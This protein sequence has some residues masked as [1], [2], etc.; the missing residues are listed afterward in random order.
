MLQTFRTMQIE[1]ILK[2]IAFLAL[3]V[4]YYIGYFRVVFDQFSKQLTNT[5]SNEETI[6]EIE[7][8]ALTICLNPPYKPL[9]FEKYGID[10]WIFEYN[11][12][13]D[14]VAN[15][16]ITVYTASQKEIHPF[17]SV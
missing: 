3:L 4:L 9:V 10:K 14:V 11:Y 7:P 6:L 8:P 15:K 1:A 5:I 2:T 12:F 16:T 17:G 13:P